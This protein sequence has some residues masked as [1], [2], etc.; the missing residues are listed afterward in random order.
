MPAFRKIPG[1]EDRNKFKILVSPSGFKESLD[2]RAT[3]DHIEVGI[4][5]V[6]SDAIIVK[7]P[8]VDGG[9]GYVVTLVLATYGSLEA[10]NVESPTGMIIPSLYG[11][12]GDDRPKIAVIEMAA[13]A[14]LRLVR[15]LLRDPELTTTY[16][17]GQII[18]AAFKSGAQGTLLGCGESDTCDA[19]VGM[20]QALGAKFYAADGSQI[21]MASGGKPLVG[22]A[23][24]VPQE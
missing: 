1:S 21:P 18:E 15:K 23:A 14:V 20:A 3:A 13:S 2:P 9:D 16:G 4:L 6:V 7:A 11:F 17:I 24:I 19:G 10:F 8:L 22:L 5:R 12:L